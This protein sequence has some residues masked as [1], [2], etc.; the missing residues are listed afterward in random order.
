MRS[1]SAFLGYVK[2]SKI[3]LFLFERYNVCLAYVKHYVRMYR[4][5]GSNLYEVRDVEFCSYTAV[6]I[7]VNVIVPQNKGT[8]FYNS[9]FSMFE[10]FDQIM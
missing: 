6:M 2:A 1:G 9:I 10:N 4:C 5:R 3:K 7:I 8:Y